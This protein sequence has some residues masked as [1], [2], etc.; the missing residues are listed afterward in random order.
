MIAMDLQRL[1]EAAGYTVI[2]PT[3]TVTSALLALDVHTPDAGVLDVNLRGEF[4]HPVAAR[5]KARNIPFILSS[6]YT[7]ADLL[8]PAYAGIRNLGKPTPPD[9][10]LA[11]LETATRPGE[12]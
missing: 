3:A 8:H 4:S 1:L 11:F 6:A 9:E 10:L 2:G 5:L 12:R 7:A